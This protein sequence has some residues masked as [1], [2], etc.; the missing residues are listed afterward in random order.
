MKRIFVLFVV[1]LCLIL[2]GCSEPLEVDKMGTAQYGLQLD[3]SP[4]RM[5]CVDGAL[6]YDSGLLSDMKTRCGTMDGGL[7][8]VGSNSSTPQKDGECNFAGASGYQHVSGITKEVLIDGD[9][10]IFKVF[11]NQ[12]ASIEEY[13]YCFCIEGRLNGAESESELVVLTNYKDITFSD[14]FM[15]VYSSQFI[16][17]DADNLCEFNYRTTEDAWGISLSTKNVSRSGLTVTIRQFGGNFSGEIQTNDWFFLEGHSEAGWHPIEKVL[18]DETTAWN[19]TLHLIRQNEET[20]FDID[21][22][23]LYGELPPGYYRLTKEI[24]KHCDLGDYETRQYST[25]FLI[26]EFEWPPN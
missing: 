14:V 2:G 21:W 11:D 25:Y 24:V 18:T 6:Y 10:V 1:A 8:Q 3:K 17:D 26:P 15:P 19:D 9:W 7:Q 4:I 22:Q 13:P 20:D 16:A 12:P 5:M 23:W